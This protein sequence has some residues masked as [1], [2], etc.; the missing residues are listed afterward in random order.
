MITISKPGSRLLPHILAAASVSIWGFTFVSTKMLIAEGLSPVNIFFY[1]FL[2]A[3][4]CILLLSRNR[5]FA[6]NIR[7]ELMMA[8]AGLS[9]GSL[10]FIAENSAL[11]ITYASNVSLIICTAPLFTMMLS[12]LFFKTPLRKGMLIGSL[13]ALAG[14]A[15]VVFNGSVNM[16]IN[17]LGDFLTFIAA[18]LWAIYCIILKITGK[19]YSTLF[20]TRK[21]FFYGLVSAALYMVLSGKQL[22]MYLLLRPVVSANLLFLGLFASMLCYLM[23]NSAV[24]SLG[25]EYAANYI[26]VVPLVTIIASVIILGEPFTMLTAAG[27]ACIIGGVYLAER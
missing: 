21:V 7:D 11:G 8:A 6:D 14:V 16:G 1:R 19:R 27:T 3:Y 26:Y 13:T 24:K 12:R 22:D 2:L 18:I 17:P 5:L 15:M 23:W 25:A 20:I 9:G 4:A 10:Y